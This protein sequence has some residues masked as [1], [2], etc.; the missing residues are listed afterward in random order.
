MRIEIQKFAHVFRAGSSIRVTVDSPSQ[1]GFWLF[2]N[3][4]RPSTNTLWHQGANASSIVLGY[5]AYP[6]AAALPEC[7]KTLR[8]PCRTNVVTVPAGTGPKAPT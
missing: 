5:V 4:T 6:H 2:G 8:Q 3:D 7:G 1:T